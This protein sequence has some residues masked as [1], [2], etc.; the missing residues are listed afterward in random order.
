[1]REHIFAKNRT[2]KDRAH[3]R[4]R[5]RG[6]AL[7]EA[8]VVIPGLLICFGAMVVAGGARYRKQ[9]QQQLAREAIFTYA[10]WGCSGAHPAR[11]PPE[12]GSNDVARV[13]AHPSGDAT[14]LDESL[15]DKNVGDVSKRF[16]TAAG[17]PPP[18]AYS[19]SQAFVSASTTITG[20]SFYFCNEQSYSAIHFF[21]YVT[22]AIGQFLP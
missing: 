17:G 18:F 3:A 14:A 11:F 4:R 16:G 13:D 19:R 9:S 12:Q 10:T 22:H 1:M 6:A 2:V 21:T 8:A 7:V 5:K 15:G 20:H